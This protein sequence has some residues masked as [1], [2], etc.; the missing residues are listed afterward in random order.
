MCV[1][2]GSSVDGLGCIHTDVLVAVWFGS[3]RVV[4]GVYMRI[5]VSAREGGAVGWASEC[6]AVWIC[7]PLVL[8]ER[9]LLFMSMY[10]HV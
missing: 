7:A 3:R 6:E 5:L 4:W 2:G 8:S 10:M 9:T 1:G